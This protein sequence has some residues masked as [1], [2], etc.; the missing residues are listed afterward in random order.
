MNHVTVAR[1]ENMN[2]RIQILLKDDMTIVED[3]VEKRVWTTNHVT[4]GGKKTWK[5]ELKC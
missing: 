5:L 3:E 1:E 2:F 4:V